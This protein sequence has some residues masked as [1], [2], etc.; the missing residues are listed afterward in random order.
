MPWGHVL[1]LLNKGLDDDAVLYYAQETIAKGW[2][3][4]KAS[5]ISEMSMLLS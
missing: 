3:W 4:E 5:H 1:R 2:K